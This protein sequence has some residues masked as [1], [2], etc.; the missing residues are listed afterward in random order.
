M[1]TIEHPRAAGL[2]HNAGFS[3]VVVATG[4]RSIHTAG[5]SSIDRARAT[6]AALIGAG[7]RWPRK[8][9]RSPCGQCRTGSWRRRRELCRHR[10][11]HDLC[12]ELPAGAPRR[13][14][15][16]ASTVLCRPV[17]S[18]EHSRRR[19]GAGAAGVARRNR[20]N[21][22]RRL[23]AAD[24]GQSVRRALTSRNG[25]RWRSSASAGRVAI[26]ASVGPHSSTCKIANPC[27]SSA[28]R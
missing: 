18:G 1:S 8:P 26:C 9:R 19:V 12:R 16:G 4:S 23:K 7:D 13:H 17:P 6:R 2:L 22:R 15:P 25:G 3:Q 5:C 10:E 11:A 27:A 24:R 20:G 28:F 14:W 21:R